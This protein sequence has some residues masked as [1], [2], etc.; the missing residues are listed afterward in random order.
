MSAADHR[1]HHV[2]LRKSLIFQEFIVAFV[3]P[4]II[5]KSGR[6]R[7]R[8]SQRHHPVSPVDVQ[9]LP[10][11][12]QIMGWVIFTVAVQIVSQP[13]MAVLPS[14]GDF[15]PKIVLVTSR[16]VHYLSEQSFAHHVQRH[17]F[18]SAEA[19]VF[20]KHERRSRFLIC[21]HQIPAVLQLI[22][23]AHLHGN[24]L[25]R[26]HRRQCDSHMALPGG[27]DNDG[28]RIFIPDHIQIIPIFC[29]SGLSGF[30]HKLR[31][32]LRPVLINVADSHDLLLLL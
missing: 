11:G 17:H 27:G 18:P 1:C 25:S 31:A 26:I 10:D 29:G 22:G 4:D 30:H 6:L 5:P 16:T 15:V 28:I 23:T 14:K 7:R 24:R 8:G 9:H 20:Q 19:A 12:A 32:L 13:V 2:S 21:L 3:F